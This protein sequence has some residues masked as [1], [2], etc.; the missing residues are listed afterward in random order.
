LTGGVIGL[1]VCLDPQ[2]GPAP[3]IT[4]TQWI[5]S[6][7][8]TGGPVLVFFLLARRTQRPDRRAALLGIATGP[9][10]GLASAFTKG[11]TGQFSAGGITAALA[12]WQLYAAGVAGITA[13]WL[14]QNAYH[15]GRLAAAQPGI[16]LADPAI[17]TAWAIVVFGEQVR[18]GLFLPLTLIPLAE[19]R[20]YD[21]SGAMPL[22]GR[23]RAGR[24]GRIQADADPWSGGILTEIP[25]ASAADLD[26]AFQ[27]ARG[28]SRTGRC[29]R[30]RSG[31][32][33]S[34]QGHRHA[35]CSA[36]PGWWTTSSSSGYPAAG[37]AERMASRG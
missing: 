24:A 3:K 8:A 33:S 10:F 4:P 37:A 36:S 22:A 16:T 2:S 5:I 17:S 23:W 35:R 14:L 28:P 13:T 19:P 25:M 34:G 7:A 18:G 11:M 1:I 27:A 15:A 30:R 21:G 9:A 32:R 6:S 26:E 31:R 29:G 12:S 20:P